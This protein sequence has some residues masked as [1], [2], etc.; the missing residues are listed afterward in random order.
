MPKSMHAVGIL[1][2]TRADQ[3]NVMT[4]FQHIKV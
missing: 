4:D 1:H 2:G 3:E